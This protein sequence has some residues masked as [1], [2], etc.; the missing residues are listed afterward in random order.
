MDFGTG[1]KRVMTNSAPDD[2][3]PASAAARAV[4]SVQLKSK[5]TKRSITV[6]SFCAGNAMTT[7]PTLS[8]AESAQRRVR[9]S[10]ATRHPAD[11]GDLAQVLQALL[12]DQ[13]HPVPLAKAPHRLATCDQ[14]ARLGDA[15]Q[16]RKPMS[17]PR[18]SFFVCARDR[19]R[20]A[21]TEK[22]TLGEAESPVR[23]LR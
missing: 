19:H 4:V 20:A 3:V 15:R 17:P 21:E 1:T 8:A 14:L 12:P 16:P 2:R 13:F 7:G 10:P 23:P 9:Q 5:G 22:R 18:R 6:F 11:L